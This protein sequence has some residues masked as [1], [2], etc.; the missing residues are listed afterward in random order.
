M[1]ITGK[2]FALS[3]DLA[4]ATIALLLM[5]FLIASANASKSRA[6]LSTA[7]MFALEKNVFFI[8]DSILKNRSDNALLGAALFDEEKRR[9]KSGELD[10][11]MFR[12]AIGLNQN[13]FFVKSVLVNKNDG[14]RPLFSQDLPTGNCIVAERLA[15]IDKEKA[16]LEVT[17][18]ELQR[19]VAVN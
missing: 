5:L 17:V 10:S 19:D 12:N 16:I 6:E 15:I 1:G 4:F 8:A 3:L 2:G 18:C 11:A 7:N 13:E 14:K 9:V